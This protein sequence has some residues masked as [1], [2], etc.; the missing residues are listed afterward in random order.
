MNRQNT[1]QHGSADV[2]APK[3]QVLTRRDL[4]AGSTAGAASLL[5]AG[6]GGSGSKTSNTGG[7]SSPM[8]PVLGAIESRVAEITNAKPGTNS[9]TIL[10]F[11]QSRS[12]F[13]ATGAEADGTV[14]G[15]FANGG[16]HVV[17]N[18]VQPDPS[19]AARA[20]PV[21]RAPVSSRIAADLPG[22]DGGTY[23]VAL[24]NALGSAFTFYHKIDERTLFPADYSLEKQ[25][26]FD[27]A[28]LKHLP[29]LSV[30]YFTAHGGISRYKSTTTPFFVFSTS[31]VV[32]G[33][34]HKDK[35]HPYYAD[36]QAGNM[37]TGTTLEDWVPDPKNPGRYMITAS[38]HY[39][40]TPRFI[41]NYKWKLDARSFVFA[42][43]C[44]GL[45]LDTPEQVTAITDLRAALNSANVSVYAGWNSQPDNLRMYDTTAYMFDRMLG[46]NKVTQIGNVATGIRNVASNPLQRPFPLDSRLLDDLTR[47]GL[48]NYNVAAITLPGHT[49]IASHLANVQLA[50][51]P[52]ETE[53]AVILAPSISS[54]DVDESKRSLTINGTF[55]TAP[56]G[57]TMNGNMRNIQ[58]WTDTQI[59]CD[60]PVTGGGDV[61]VTVNGHAS[62]PHRLTQWILPIHYRGLPNGD[63]DTHTE[64]VDL[65]LLMRLDPYFS[66]GGPGATV[67]LTGGPDNLQPLPSPGSTGS[68]E[69]SGTYEGTPSGTH[70]VVTYT[71]KGAL[72]PPNPPALT[73]EFTFN[74][75]INFTPKTM[76]LGFSVGVLKAGT[77]A[78]GNPGAIIETDLK[79][80]LSS[81][82]WGDSSTGLLNMTLDK[83]YNIMPGMVERSVPPGGGV[84]G[85]PNMKTTLTWDKTAPT[86]GTEP[87]GNQ[88]RSA[89]QKS[90]SSVPPG[91]R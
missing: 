51:N 83:D 77:D 81:Y 50:F 66:R 60:L 20:A 39:A 19:P 61:I 56:G 89:A 63:G 44:S 25:T 59:V 36:I 43:A 24:L 67:P 55:G 6:C 28:Y 68:Y 48:N 18:T 7:S 12:E 86:A 17:F 78:A 72:K 62:P 4:L 49:T 13:V 74:P 31:T 69:V 35:S 82:Y 46:G 10:Q 70:H 14:W 15:Q 40:I 5:L 58:Q 22:S 23:R 33:D 76:T 75:Q 1:P 42:S 88:A 64:S 3:P 34:P 30:L 65:M 79:F 8:T 87:N 57:V 38:T 54:L 73:G 90:V 21:I 84:T 80:G 47:V 2:G 9:Q 53:A 52:A 16:I 41:R 26:A 32:T 91:R 27:V 85:Q 71:G 11:M 45:A 37:V 29:P